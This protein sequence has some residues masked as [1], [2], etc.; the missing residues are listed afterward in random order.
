MEVNGPAVNQHIS[1]VLKFIT[2]SIC[3]R[4]VTGYL[5]TCKQTNQVPISGPY[6]CKNYFNFAYLYEQQCLNL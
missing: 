4:I 6:T 1:T 3:P 2:L 5:H